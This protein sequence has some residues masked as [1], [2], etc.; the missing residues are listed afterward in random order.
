MDTEKG[1]THRESLFWK[2]EADLRFLRRLAAFLKYV[3]LRLAVLLLAAHLSFVPLLEAHDIPAD[4]MVRAFV[5]PEG[6][7]LRVLIRM[8]MT[9]IHEIE[10]PVHKEDGMLDL[11]K[12]D[13]FLREAAK[14][15]LGDKMDLLRGRVEDRRLIRS[16]PCGCHWKVTKPS[17]HMRV[18]LTQI[19]GPPLPFDTKLLPT[20]GV[21]DAL[22]EYP[23]QSD[24]SRFSLHPKFERFGLRVVTVL[25]LL[26][27]D[28]TI[29]AFEYEGGDPGILRLDPQWH[30]AA[31]TFVKMGFRHILDGADHL[32]FLF[33]LVIPFRNFR[34]LIPVVTAFTVAHSITLIASAYDMAPGMP[35]FP[36]LIETL[37]A[38]SIVYMALENIV[39]INP[40]RRW[41]ITFG[42]GLVHGFGFSFALRRT[43]QFAGSHLLTSLVSFNI[44]VELGQIFMLA[45][46]VPALGILFRYVD[47]RIGTIILSAL[48][49]HTAWHWMTE[50]YEQLSKFPLDWP[51]IDAGFIAASL[52][53]AMIVVALAGAWWLFGLLRK[54]EIR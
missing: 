40:K 36:P 18:R 3:P 50:R 26:P 17:R 31:W 12:I 6:G 15:W 20:Q 34:G 21:L 10:W 14:K 19:T 16:P 38:A 43:L 2:V 22:F 32:L 37:I 42:F 46:M 48:A 8:Q 9:S 7:H 25:R 29:R 47:V 54:R 45:L 24:R 1:S 4:A 5:K 11:A 35:W 27:P 49:T 30:Q 33:C 39:V 41:M 13:P 51:D 23:I 53:W 28:G 44:G 52:R